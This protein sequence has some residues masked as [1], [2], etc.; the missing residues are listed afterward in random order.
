MLAKME[1]SVKACQ[2]KQRSLYQRPKRQQQIDLPEERVPQFWRHPREGFLSGIEF[3][4]A[5]GV[6]KDLLVIMYPLFDA[7]IMLKLRASLV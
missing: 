1:E 6:G 4:S 3:C 2:M 7:E 5:F